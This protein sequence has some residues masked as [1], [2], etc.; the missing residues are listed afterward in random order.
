MAKETA[1]DIQAK[2]EA[3]DELVSSLESY[4]SELER[5]LKIEK[6]RH[7][8]AKNRKSDALIE[9]EFYK[10]QLEN[11]RTRKILLADTIRLIKEEA[12]LRNISEQEAVIS[13]AAEYS[14]EIE[15]LNKKKKDGIAIDEERL[16][17]LKDQAV[18]FDDASDGVENLN[19]KMNELDVADAVTEGLGDAATAAEHLGNEF[20]RTAESILGISSNWRQAGLTGAFLNGIDKGA[21]FNQVIANIGPKLKETLNP[22]NLLGNAIT[23]LV[24]ASW[25]LTKALDGSIAEFKQVTGA[26]DEYMGVLSD[27]T[28][29][30]YA[31]GISSDEAMQSVSALY[32]ELAMYTS[33]SKEAQTEIADVSTKLKVMGVDAQTTAKTADLLMQSVGYTKD[34][35]VGFQQSLKSMSNAIKVPMSVLNSQFVEAADVIGKYGKKGVEEFKKLAAAAK[36]TGIEMRSLLDI[37]GQFDTFEDAA[38]RVG[39]LNAILGGAYFDTVQMVNATEEQRIDLLRRGVQASGKTFDQLGRYE[40]KAI[41]AAAGINDINEANKLFGQ[42]TAAYE[43]LQQLA[44][45]ASMSLA[46]L[47]EEAFNTL[48]P[49]QKLQAVFKKFQ[50]PLDMILKLI[51]LIGTFLYK[52]VDGWEK[53]AASVGITGEGFTYLNGTIL[54]LLFSFKKLG[55]FATAGS[56]IMTTMAAKF[57]ILAAGMTKAGAA[58]ATFGTKLTAFGTAATASAKGILAVG[59][60]LLMMGKGISLAATGLAELVK[61]FKDL[62]GGEIA[63]AL[64]ALTIVMGGFILA[65]FALSAAATVGAVPLL[66]LG[67]ALLMMGGAIALAAYGMSLLVDSVSGLIDSLSNIPLENLL[68]LIGAV[69]TLAIFGA[70]AGLGLSAIAVGLLAIGAAMVFIRDEEIKLLASMFTS[71]GMIKLES[72]QTIGE[73]ALNLEKLTQVD[74]ANIEKVTKNLSAMT[75]LTTGLNALA[76]TLAKITTSLSAISGTKVSVGADLKTDLDAFSDLSIGADLKTDLDAFSDLSIGAG[77]KTDLD[78]FSD[79]SIGAD[80]KTD[81]DA[82]SDLSIPV[83]LSTFAKDLGTIQDSDGIKSS[84]LLI[85]SVSKLT[86]ETTKAASTVIK[87]VAVLAKTK[88]EANTSELISA[89]TKLLQH[90]KNAAPTASTVA[91]KDKKIELTVNID[92]KKAWKGIKP[93]YEEE[94]S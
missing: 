65:I 67:A 89:L 8:L 5:S 57:P 9:S 25:E 91:G 74:T 18:T 49:M 6:E 86:P 39:Q 71:I 69:T 4:R 79:L 75:E 56:A 42:S 46:D 53:L 30:N 2:R 35:F 50:K 88:A 92:G 52:M 7:A 41:A 29:Q 90:T 21:G 11:I 54:L 13:L 87:E 55:F 47:S 37:A 43:E 59:A 94:R 45:D 26:G 58:T 3:T 28:G 32:T 66:A 33:L 61:S 48:S 70:L 31:C 73:L 20:N 40:K 34:E 85:E 63:G 84:A 10:K 44:G 12:D 17:Q 15:E 68:G 62:S 80:L 76:L 60:A 1:K 82:F 23:K 14:K 19:K 51:D 36:A 16:K 81:L 72:A 22:A 93:Y 78:A 64:L 38:E 83:G 24:K 27:V 77:L